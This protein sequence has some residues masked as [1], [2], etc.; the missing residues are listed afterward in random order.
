VDPLAAQPEYDGRYDPARHNLDR[1]PT[2]ALTG[3]IGE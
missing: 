2:S 1:H 3:Q